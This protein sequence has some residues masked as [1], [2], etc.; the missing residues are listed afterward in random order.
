VPPKGDFFPNIGCN[1]LYS[2]QSK[3]SECI[4]LIDTLGEGDRMGKEYKYGILKVC[5][6]EGVDLSRFESVES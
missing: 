6:V 5:L 4:V 2:L 3:C 1:F